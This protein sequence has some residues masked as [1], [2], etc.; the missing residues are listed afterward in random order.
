MHMKIA[1]S[2]LDNFIDSS[3][4]DLDVPNSIHVYQTLKAIRKFN[5]YANKEL[6]IVGLIHDLEVL[7]SLEEPP[8]LRCWRRTYVVG[9]EFPKSIVCYDSLKK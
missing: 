3:D 9:C 1:L 6:Q 5:L 7:F 8:L 4:P 2:L